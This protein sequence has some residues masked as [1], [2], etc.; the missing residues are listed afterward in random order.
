MKDFEKYECLF[1]NSVKE[2]EEYVRPCAEEFKWFIGK[3]YNGIF[4]SVDAEL[5]YSVIRKHKP[6]LIIEVGSGHS[7]FFAL[8]AVKKNGS[9]KI[10]CVDPSPF[11]QV[12]DGVQYIK[13]RVE[14]VAM[15]FFKQLNKNDILF[16]DSSHRTEEAEYH[17]R[18]ILPNLNT[19]VVIHHH[20]FA[21][22]WEIYYH[23]DPRKY[24]E[25]DL[26]LDFYNRHQDNFKVLC[27]ASYAQYKNFELVQRLIKSRKWCPEMVPLSLWIRKLD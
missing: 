22:P 4:Q 26:I 16:F 10:V 24:G 12:P 11:R 27:S 2:F 14:D 23:N 9:G 15:G 20:D 19:G 8:D 7:T 3:I 5:Y 21:Y 17:F 25:P 18:K 13:S 6:N 1:Q